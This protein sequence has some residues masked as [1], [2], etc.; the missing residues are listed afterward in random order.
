M[1]SVWWMCVMRPQTV[2]D[3]MRSA[4]LLMTTAST[5]AE[6]TVTPMMAAAQVK[7]LSSSGQGQ[8]KDW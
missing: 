7:I 2:T 5:V 8:V 1:A 3:M 4:M 6:T